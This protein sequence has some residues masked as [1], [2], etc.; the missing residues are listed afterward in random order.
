MVPLL[1]IRFR[2]TRDGFVLRPPEEL[3]KIGFERSQVVIV[4]ESHNGMLR[5]RRT[6]EVGR[7]LLPVAHDAGVR[8]LAMEALT[9]HFASEANATRLLPASRGEGYLEQPDM[10][11]LIGDALKLG[12]MLFA[13][14]CRFE[15]YPKHGPDAFQSLDFAN[16]RDLDEARNLAE[17]LAGDGQGA[18][19]LIWCGNSHQRKTP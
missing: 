6:R 17:F 8:W 16:W 7:R 3:L 11:D 2:H 15:F 10:R 12:W 9:P 4:N 19:L 14:E 13:Y 1:P 18:K 5:C